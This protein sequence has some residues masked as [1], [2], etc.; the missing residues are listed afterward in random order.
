MERQDI[1]ALIDKIVIIP[2]TNILLYLYK[3]SFSTSNNLVT[4]FQKV[5]DKLVIPFR[6]H[7]EYEKH[8]YEEQAKIDSKYDTFTKDIKKLSTEKQKKITDR[9]AETRKYDFPDIDSLQSNLDSAFSGTISV[10]DNYHSSLSSEKSNQAQQ[11][12]AVEDLVQCLVDEGKIRRTPSIP[13]IL[14]YIREA[15]FRYK[16]KMP[17]GYMD[18]EN[19]DNEVAKD[20][21]NDNFYGR[22]RKYGDFFIWKDILEIGRELP[23]DYHLLFLTNDVKEDWWVVRGEAKNLQAIRMR[24]ELLDEYLA[25]V[26]NDRI[27]F[28]RLVDFY[29]MFSDYYQIQDTKTQLELDYDD[30]VQTIVNEKHSTLV[31]SSIDSSIR[32]IDWSSIIDESDLIEPSVECCDYSIQNINIHY[33]TPD[34]YAIYDVQMY[35][36]TYPIEIFKR[37]DREKVF[38]GT[39]ELILKFMFEIQRDLHQLDDESIELK[40][41]AYE[42]I[43]HKDPWEVEKNSISDALADMA[44]TLEQS[45]KH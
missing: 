22:T 16:Y 36:P 15:E 43:N 24:D 2:D 30:Y 40:T 45:Y 20:K 11:I 23:E 18:E 38:L 9:I 44:D 7:D 3:C 37:G 39:I 8:K 42:A 25:Y 35:V 13:T 31:E 26:G 32:E 41:F 10:I 28:I 12:A 19:K 6:V 27:D 34:E 29:S 17:P 33:D 21:K 4:L 5:K 14:E 1:D